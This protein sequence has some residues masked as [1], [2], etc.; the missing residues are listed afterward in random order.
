MTL[1]CACIQVLCAVVYEAGYRYC[2]DDVLC[3]HFALRAAP[4]AKNMLDLG[5]GLACSAPL[6]QHPFSQNFTLSIHEAKGETR[7]QFGSVLCGTCCTG[8]GT[9][10]LLWLAQEPKPWTPTM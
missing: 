10:G 8:I 5:S 4:F 1:G 7:K 3:E 2:A 6:N 9:I